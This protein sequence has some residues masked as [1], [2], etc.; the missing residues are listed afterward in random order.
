MTEQKIHYVARI[1]VERVTK[2]MEVVKE[3]DHASRNNAIS[4][5][6]SSRDISLVADLTFSAEDVAKLS[7]HIGKHIELITDGELDSL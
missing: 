1:K 4:Q 7:A 5:S 6:E 3:Y 2:N